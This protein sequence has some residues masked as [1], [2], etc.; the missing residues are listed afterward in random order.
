M[1]V[2]YTSSPSPV[3]GTPCRGVPR[4]LSQWNRSSPWECALPSHSLI[5]SEPHSMRGSSK[6]ILQMKTLRHLSPSKAIGFCLVGVRESFGVLFLL[7]HHV[8]PCPGSHVPA[9][10]ALIHKYYHPGLYSQPVQLP[11]P[12]LTGIHFTFYNVIHS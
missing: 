1:L 12:T 3:P 8:I 6:P 11:I 7:Q 4:R 9:N 10:K 5:Q 2:S